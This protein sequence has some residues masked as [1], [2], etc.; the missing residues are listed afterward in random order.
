MNNEKETSNE[1]IVA[2][3]SEKIDQLINTVNEIKIGLQNNDIRMRKIEERLIRQEEKDT[4]QQ[5][6]IEQVKEVMSNQK[7]WVMGMISG[8][9]VSIVGIVLKIII[10]C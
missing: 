7:K 4:S 9:V 3:F 5:K 1:T 8:I 10:G 2:V 6:E